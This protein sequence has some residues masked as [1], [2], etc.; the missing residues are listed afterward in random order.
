MK[1]KYWAMYE[2]VVFDKYYYWHYKARSERISRI[3]KG[4]VTVCTCGGIAAWFSFSQWQ[5]A[6]AIIIGISQVIGAL[7]YLYPYSRQI[8]TINFYL[9]DLKLLIARIDHVWDKVNG[10]CQPVLSDEDVSDFILEFSN[11]QINLEQKYIGDTYFPRSKCVEQK[12]SKDSE[13]YMNQRFYRDF[14]K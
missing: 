14:N 12:A 4:F 3:I 11:A 6:W 9:P 8:N 2:Q 13:D 7:D 1:V 10:A 5:I